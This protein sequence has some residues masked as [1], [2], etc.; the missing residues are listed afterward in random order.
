MNKN[1]IFKFGGASIATIERAKNLAQILQN[2]TIKNPV[3]VISAIGK[4]TNGLEKVVDT[5]FHNQDEALKLL[6][7]VKQFHFQY[8]DELFENPSQVKD[9]VNN[10]FIEAHWLLE[11]EPKD[12]YDYVY[13]QIV[14]LG[15]IVST[16]I[17]SH[18]L[19]SIGVDNIWIDARGI[20]RTN[21]QFRNGIIHWEQ[22]QKAVQK[23][24]TPYLGKKI[25]ITQGF[26]GC[27]SDNETT[28]LGREGSDFTGAILANCIDA[29]C[30]TIWKDVTG[31]YNCDPNQFNDAIQLTELTYREAVEMTYYGA[32]VI[33]P[34]TIKPLQNK[35]IPLR[36]R[37]FL[38]K[39]N[40]GTIIQIDSKVNIPRAIFI[41][42][43]NQIL[44]KFYTK[45]F[46][47]FDEHNFKIAMDYLDKYQANI[48]LIQ[49]GAVNCSFV[50][51]ASSNILENI[52]EIENSFSHKIYE[53]LTLNTLRHSSVDEREQLANGK[54][55]FLEQR[56]TN[57]YQIAF[58]D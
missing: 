54:T 6:E 58:K 3:V 20:I 18:Y 55:I 43:T 23:Q 14:S 38:D 42:K 29:E 51:D 44:L 30:L 1:N 41:Q 15:E 21:N 28:T 40:T 35:A 17:I 52:S 27:T 39:E 19:Q 4:V 26:I 50:F 53:G 47:F 48:N 25:I 32:K 46:S 9:F 13:D 33:H 12:S 37:S 5:F 16:T 56:S 10:H 34:K 24:L 57:T 2:S 7:D 22:T 45:D 11:D 36:V 8:C 49:R 31:V